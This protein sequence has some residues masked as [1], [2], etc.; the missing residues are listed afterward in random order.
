MVRTWLAV[1]HYRIHLIENWPDGARK[2][3]SLAS[4]LSA[5]AALERSAPLEASEFVCEICE[6]RKKV[7]LRMAA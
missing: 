6:S 7:E 5:L 2:K 1:E 4:A 3:A